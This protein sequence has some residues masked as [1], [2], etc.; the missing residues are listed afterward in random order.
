MEKG[1]H[2]T[3][4]QATPLKDLSPEHDGPDAAWFVRIPETVGL[5]VF[6]VCGFEVDR[7]KMGFEIGLFR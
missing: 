2:I 3:V 7:F 4:L 5:A 6:K 1:L